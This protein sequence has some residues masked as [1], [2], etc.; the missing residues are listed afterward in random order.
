VAPTG[1]DRWV[2]VSPSQFTHETEGLERVRGVLPQQA[3]F[4]AW[5]NFE[6]RDNRG[7]WHEVDLLVL[8]RRQL[9]LVELK[10]YSGRLSGDDHTWLRSGRRAED[11]PLKLARRKSQYFASKL[12]DEFR[13]WVDE[14]QVRDA[15]PDREV[16]PFVQESVFLHHP[17]FVCDLSPASAIGLYG[18]DGNSSTSN[19]PGI[20]DLLLEPADP[21]RTIHERIIVELMSRIGLVQRRE[22]EVG[23][24]V[25][26]DEAL[27][28]GEGWQEWAATHLVSQQRRARI[29]FQV[30]KPGARE[31]ERQRVL[32]LADHEYRVMS[33]LNHEAVLRPEDIIN[34]ELG[35]GL[36]YPVDDD[37]QRLDLWLAEQPDGISLETRLSIIRQIGEALQYAHGNRVV[38]R[39]LNPQAIW[40]RPSSDGVRVQ[41]RDWRS[42]G[43]VAAEQGAA[44]VTGVTEI[45]GAHD[46]DA[47]S[48]RDSWLDSF[49][50]PEG[51]LTHGVDRVRIDVFGLGAIAFYLLADAAPAKS[52]ASL[53]T[54]LHEQLGLDLAPEVPEIS[55]NLRSAVLNATRPAVTERTAD[56][57][58]FLAQLEEA[59]D[60]SAADREPES[61]PLDASPGA[62]IGGRFRLVRRLGTGSTAVGLL[63]RD[64]QDATTPTEV[65]KV[66]IDDAAGE[67]LRAEAEVL[68]TLSHPRF[69]RLIEGPLAI[70]GRQALLLESAGGQTL[71][72]AMSGRQRLSLDWLERWGDDLL[73]ALTELDAAGIDHRD[74]KP[75]NLGVRE[76][77]SRRSKHLVLFD[78]SLSRAAASAVSAGT[79]PYLDPFLGLGDRNRYD[80]AAER[81]AAAVVLFEMATGNPPVYGDGLSDPAVISDEAT[82]T[83]EL[84]DQTVAQQ[85]ITFF[86]RALARDSRQRYDTAAEMLTIWKGIFRQ[87]ET[88]V[89][90]NADELQDKATAETQLIYAG[91][92]ARALSALEP[93][94]VATVGDLVAV[95]PARLSRLSGVADNTRKEVRKA[96]GKWRTKFGASIR[97]RHV[98]SR[99]RTTILPDP[100]AMAEQLLSVA[101]VGRATSRISLVTHML[102]INGNL[103]AFATQAKIAANLPEPIKPARVNQL[104][105]ELQ[106]LWASDD[107]TRQSLIKLG[108]QINGRIGELGGVATVDELVEHL[109]TVMVENPASDDNQETRLVAGLIR[110]VVDRQRAVLRG[111]DEDAVELV[112]RRREGRPVLV[113]TDSMLL[114]AVE[115]LGRLADGLVREVN[116][117]DDHDNLVPAPRVA[118]RLIAALPAPESVPKRLRDGGRLARLAAV[119]SSHT[120]ASSSQEL[121]HRELGPAAAL[122]YTLGAVA[123]GQSL[124]PAEIR[125]RV[126]VR[127]P[128]IAPL[129]QHPRL[130]RI[131]EESGIGLRYD[132]RSRRYVMPAP[133][134]DTTGL[135]TRVQTAVV[136]E[137]SSVST[138]GVVGQ[139]LADS[140]ARRSFLALA[141]EAV[142]LNRLVDVLEQTYNATVVNVT[143]ILLSAMHDQAE[144][145]RLPWPAVLDADAQPSATRAAQGLTA[146]VTRTLPIVESKIDDALAQPGEGP[147]V[148]TDAAVLARYGAVA[149]LSRW[150]D[151]A[152]SR[153]R[154]LWL[155]VPQLFANRG[156]LL[157]GKPLPLAAPGQLVHV[158]RDWIA[159]RLTTAAS[160]AQEGAAS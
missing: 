127:F 28:E 35:V 155:I 92:S 118:E 88:G 70:A 36:V 85:M 111:G 2:E 6:F 44:S 21:R 68:Q 17:Q 154:P 13:N 1:D 61:D 94:R 14:R 52:A 148:L 150:T 74:I 62:L 75:A 20:S 56:V 9:H 3:P 129:P 110:V 157:D 145:A 78:F 81:Y 42:A 102:G 41:V 119:L 79:P 105:A 126:R 40:I 8:G 19:L 112:V 158:D 149:R 23:S 151:L 138:L 133:H 10:Y 104:V 113:A 146:L 15:P 156:A 143:E 83:A 26:Q 5:S 122:V 51:A 125:D 22:R 66:A 18:I 99:M 106:E 59:E 108:E 34:D 76:D 97:V 86:Q 60:Q 39:G 153:Q 29:R 30:V 67:R 91:L 27:V 31:G 32:R 55:S 48:K 142:Q 95:D 87:T 69:V 147:V 25:I 53:R 64:E 134:H 54:R 77:R 152:S 130:D 84:F 140:L 117:A 89:P 47:D 37:W 96:A 71:A 4:R 73:T 103:D 49:A 24:W 136:T 107:Q 141:P 7:R 90:V 135:E 131:V 144:E 124:P 93:Y 11:S 58:S 98:S 109:M 80:S 128:S 63:V 50:A 72:Q 120:A 46:D 33:R 38:H 139:R 65:L 115:D 12:K 160:E 116:P 137:L 114:D 123:P 100:M 45:V 82:V 57:A 159:S 132:D 16:V 121:H 101:R 43:S